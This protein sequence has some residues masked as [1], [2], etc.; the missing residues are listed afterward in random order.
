MFDRAFPDLDETTATSDEART[1]LRETRA[2]FGG[3]P[4]VV[5]RMASSPALY[6]AFMAQVHAFDATSLSPAERETVILVV[7]R[8]IGCSVCVA[9]HRP[10]LTK[11][12]GAEVT[13]ALLDRAE[14]PVARLRALAEYAQAL[15]DTRGDVGEDAWRSFLANG[16]SHEQALEVVL[17]VGAYT[18]STFANRLTKGTLALTSS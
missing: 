14:L 3:V 10:L 12:A 15:L 13:R 8:E 6:R 2:Q 5:A 4:R 9:L 11:A 1:I 18:M 7:A 17:G 16:Y